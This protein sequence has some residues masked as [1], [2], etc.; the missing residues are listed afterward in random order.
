MEVLNDLLGYKDRKIYQNTDW[1]SFTLDSVLLADFVKIK[2]NDKNIIDIGTGTGAIPLI[3]STK[4]NKIIDAIEIQQDVANL[5]RKTIIYNKLDDQINLIVDDILNYSKNINN[6]YD[7]VIS[8]PPYYNDLKKN[9]T[10]EKLIARHEVCLDLKSLIKVS[11]KILKNNGKLFLVYNSNRFLELL[12]ELKN[13]NL[14]PKRIR[15]V[16]QNK[17]KEASMVLIECSKN[18]NPGLKIESPIIIKEND[19]KNTIE[20]ERILVGGDMIES[21][22]L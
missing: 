7:I 10:K 20:Y 2:N 11:K 22:K 16:H 4:T 6:Y 18:G 21:K 8:N 9:I 14:V 15:F 19:S 3:L 5:F 12:E 13:N 1:F 17:N